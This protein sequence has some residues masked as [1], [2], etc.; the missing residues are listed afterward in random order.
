MLILINGVNTSKLVVSNSMDR[1]IDKNDPYKL[2]HFIYKIPTNEYINKNYEQFLEMVMPWLD[3]IS[4]N[5]LLMD[6][7]NARYKSFAGTLRV[8]R[9]GRKPSLIPKKLY[10]YILPHIY[11]KYIQMFLHQFNE[12]IQY[13]TINIHDNTPAQFESVTFSDNNNLIFHVRPE[14]KKYKIKI[15]QKLDPISII[16]LSM[17]G[18]M[19][20]IVDD[21][22]NVRKLLSIDYP[23]YTITNDGQYIIYMP[24]PSYTGDDILYV[25]I[26][27]H[28]RFIN[29][30]ISNGNSNPLLNHIEKGDRTLQEQQQEQQQ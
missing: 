23:H 12:I 1:L 19:E 15:G 13:T 16:T 22:Y 9:T 30:K 11:T 14:F 26:N 27:G 10:K 7:Y 21:Q 18:R 6:N 4:K 17:I 8:N 3:N 5:Y 29:I 28:P 25:T 2:N 20:Q 24:P